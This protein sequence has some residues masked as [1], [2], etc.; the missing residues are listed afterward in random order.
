[1]TD[2]TFALD[3]RNLTVSVRLP[4]GQRA[5]VLDDVSFSVGVG[6]TVGLVGESGSGK[7]M[8]SMA[9]MGLLPRMARVEGGQILLD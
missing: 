8:T 6:G 3:V 1:M 4:S 5:T 7:T 2:S 9:I